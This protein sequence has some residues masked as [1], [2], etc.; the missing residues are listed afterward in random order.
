MGAILNLNLLKLLYF[1]F[2][3]VG[4][5]RPFVYSFT[6]IFSD[7]RPLIVDGG[8]GLVCALAAVWNDV[9]VQRC[10]VHYAE[11]RIMPT[12]AAKSPWAL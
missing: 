4:S 9:P 11:F 2:I 10:T 12:T 7:F 6:P 1:S 3:S 5:V 8:A